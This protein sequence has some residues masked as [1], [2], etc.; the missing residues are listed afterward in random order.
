MLARHWWFW[1]LTALV[2][3]AAALSAPRYRALAAAARRSAL[4]RGL[5]EPGSGRRV[6]TEP[7]GFFSDLSWLPLL[8]GTWVCL[9]PWIWGYDDVSGAV[10][11]DVVTGALVIAVTLAATMIP[12]LAV[13][14]VLSGTWLLVAPWIAGYGTEHGPVGLSDTLAGVAIAAL[15]IVALVSATRRLAPGEA[16][17]VG[18]IRPRG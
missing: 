18:R 8:F 16:G 17:P 6:E 10:A 9:G 5:V 12:S 7:G 3:G 13:L 11:T 1:I 4:G 14:N 15:A 2:V